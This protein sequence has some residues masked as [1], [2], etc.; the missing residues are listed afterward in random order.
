LCLESKGASFTFKV[1][2]VRDKGQSLRLRWEN[3][4]L[5]F[6]I[7]ALGL[8]TRAKSM[9]S[10]LPSFLSEYAGDTLYALMVFFGLGCLFPKRSTWRVAAMAFGLCLCLEGSQLYHAPWIDA[11][12]HTR[13]GGLILGFGFLWSDLFCYAVGVALG[14]VLERLFRR[15]KALP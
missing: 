9:Q 15:K 8:A 14:V 11:L 5:D 1:E 6:Y 7:I 4:F 13:W 10:F 2:W 3:L 12:R